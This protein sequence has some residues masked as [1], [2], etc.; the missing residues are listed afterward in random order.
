M[1]LCDV[2]TKLF[3]DSRKAAPPFA[4]DNVQND[5]YVVGQHGVLCEVKWWIFVALFEENYISWFKKMSAYYHYII[6]KR[7]YRNNKHFSE[8]SLTIK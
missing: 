3:I 5:L 2:R 8:I 4:T 1:G 7:W 6:L